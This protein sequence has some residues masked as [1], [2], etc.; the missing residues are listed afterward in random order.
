MNGMEKAY[1]SEVWSRRDER[2]GLESSARPA[3]SALAADARWID[4]NDKTQKQCLPWIGEPCLFAHGGQTY[5][6]RHTGGSFQTGQGVTARN[7]PTWDCVWM[8]LPKAP[9][10]DSGCDSGSCG[11]GD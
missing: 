1:S 8:P 5:Y 9:N 2:Q 10:S 6:G 4:P 7:F 3:S 11:G